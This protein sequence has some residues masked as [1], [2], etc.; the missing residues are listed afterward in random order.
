MTGSEDIRLFL[1]SRRGRLKPAKAGLPTYGRQ[2]RVPG[3]RREEVALLAGIS[4]DYY[5]RLERGNAQGVS[6]EV[7]DAI[8]GALQLGADERAHH[9]N[10]VRAAN[11]WALDLGRPRPTRSDHPSA[12]SSMA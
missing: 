8:A 2:R 7:L 4:V 5:T 10:L 9:A 6:D 3:L 12:G 11:E 1:S